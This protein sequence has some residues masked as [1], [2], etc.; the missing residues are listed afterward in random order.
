MD[1]LFIC[2]GR[3]KF[4]VSDRTHLYVDD[5]G[6]RPNKVGTASR[7]HIGK[8]LGLLPI[9][10]QPVDDSGRYSERLLLQVIPSMIRVPSD[11]IAIGDGWGHGDSG[12]DD[13]WNSVGF[14]VGTIHN[15]G[16]N[17]VFCDGHV[18]HAKQLKWVEESERARRRWN[19]DNEPHPETWQTNSDG[20]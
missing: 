6:Y 19:N 7:K 15:R 13:R 10:F 11:M 1:G 12:W 20:L 3:R 4:R 2:P 9:S 18:E 8:P 16:A 17:M 5:L 14:V